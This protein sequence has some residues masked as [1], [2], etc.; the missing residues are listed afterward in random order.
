MGKDLEKVN[1]VPALSLL[2]WH[3]RY[4]QQAAWT[5]PLRDYLYAKLDLP[6]AQRVL[7]VGCGTGALT[8]ELE[9]FGIGQAFGVDLLSPPLGLARQTSPQ[10]VFAQ[11]DALSLPFPPQSFDLAYCHFLLLWVRDPFRAVTEMVRVVRP[12][13]WVLALAEPDYG[14]RIQYPPAL[15]SL[16]DW[17]RQA[18]ERQ[19]AD[20][21]VGRKLA[22]LFHRAGL[23]DVESGVLGG[24]WRQS[25]SR[26][27]WEAEWAVIRSDLE[28]YL[29]LEA[30]DH[31]Q[32]VDESAWQNGE[33]VWFV[34]TFY[35]CGKVST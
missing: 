27:E 25:S 21:R 16:G 8:A 13:G 26:Q 2:D 10:A 7:E 35:A 17:Q 4:L 32:D 23:K 15:D 20:P 6:R 1:R 18:L 31:F 24:Q 12:G 3:Q 14:G 19:G 29:S 28:P 5:R 33:R 30:L 11:A 9:H 22:G 34:P